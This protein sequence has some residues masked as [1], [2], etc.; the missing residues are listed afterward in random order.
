MLVG[1]GLV[2]SAVVVLAWLL[3][4][5]GAESLTHLTSLSRLRVWLHQLRRDRELFELKVEMRDHAARLRRELEA[6]FGS[7][8]RR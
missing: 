3:V 1:V 5:H 6:E 4:E 8:S 7:R 2:M